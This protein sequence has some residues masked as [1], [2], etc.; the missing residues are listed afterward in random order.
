MDPAEKQAVKCTAADDVVCE[1]SQRD[2]NVWL[3]EEEQG[4]YLTGIAIFFKNDGKNSLKFSKRVLTP[5]LNFMLWIDV[6][7]EISFWLWQ[8][9][10][11][12]VFWLNQR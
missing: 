4:R 1:S 10:T 5:T 8:K 9:T 3:T 7:H 6:Q 11:K 12:T 2:V